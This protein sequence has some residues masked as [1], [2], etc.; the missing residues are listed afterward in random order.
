MAS[1]QI[2]AKM[3][4]GSHLVLNANGED[5]SSQCPIKTRYIRTPKRTP[6]NTAKVTEVNDFISVGALPNWQNMCF[7]YKLNFPISFHVSER[8]WAKQVYSELGHNFSYVSLELDSYP[9]RDAQLKSN[10]PGIKVHLSN[11][12]TLEAKAEEL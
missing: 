5:V 10:K 1:S 9:K 2:T 7:L 12:S 11:T 3:P 4:K 8:S 6:P